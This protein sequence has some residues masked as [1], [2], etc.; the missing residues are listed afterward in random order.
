MGV[1]MRQVAVLPRSRT[2]DMLSSRNVPAK[3]TSHSAVPAFWAFQFRSTLLRIE[4]GRFHS[5][6][7][8]LYPTGRHAGAIETI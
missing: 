3:S 4:D 6:Q 2:L 7:H 1:V 8:R 5:I